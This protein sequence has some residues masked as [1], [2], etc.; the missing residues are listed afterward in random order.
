MKKSILVEKMKVVYSLV[1][2]TFHDYYS[3]S[4][5]NKQRSTFQVIVGAAIFYMPTTNDLYSGFMSVNAKEKLGSTKETKLVKEHSFPRKVGGRL[6]YELYKKEIDRGGELTLDDF[7]ELYQT[8]LGKYNFVLKEE[9]E[10]LK[11]YQKI[12]DQLD[13]DSFLELI[14]NIETRTYQNAGVRLCNMDF[15]LIQKLKK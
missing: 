12:S 6:L 14:E 11:Q 5:S 15:G 7:V 13:S 8:R 3:E 4:T 9:N 1:K 2:N 10:K